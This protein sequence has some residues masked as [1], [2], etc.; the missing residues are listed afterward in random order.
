VTDAFSWLELYQK[1]SLRGKRGGRDTAAGLR[2]TALTRTSA[3]VSA[4]GTSGGSAGWRR[5]SDATTTAT[6]AAISNTVPQTIA[7]FRSFIFL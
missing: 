3:G 5:L 7:I 6:T 4:T 1:I 2:S